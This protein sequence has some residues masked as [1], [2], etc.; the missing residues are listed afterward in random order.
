MKAVLKS[1]TFPETACSPV[2]TCGEHRADCPTGRVA[3]VDGVPVAKV[4]TPGLS[5][6]SKYLG[7]NS[8]SPGGVQGSPEMTLYALK[9]GNISQKSWGTSRCAHRLREMKEIFYL[10]LFVRLCTSKL[11]D[12]LCSLCRLPRNFCFHSWDRARL[13]G[14]WRTSLVSL[15]EAGP[16]GSVPTQLATAGPGGVM[17]GPAPAAAPLGGLRRDPG[18]TF[19]LTLTSAPSAPGYARW[20]QQH[21]YPRAQPSPKASLQIK[22]RCRT[23][24]ILTSTDSD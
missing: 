4:E 1:S 20:H 13:P 11:N 9:V 12:A 21:S 7:A 10:L 17:P 3:Q 15:Q 19:T 22:T 6:Q 5:F 16:V 18:L 8:G 2:R 14:C 24:F 23:L